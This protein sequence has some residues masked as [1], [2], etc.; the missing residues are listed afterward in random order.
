MVNT[1]FYKVDGV[2]YGMEYWRVSPH[3]WECRVR[4][5]E[6]E[7]TYIFRTT[8]YDYIDEEQIRYRCWLGFSQ[9]LFR[10]AKRMSAVSNNVF[11]HFTT[12]DLLL[13]QDKGE[14]K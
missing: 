4:D 10:R 7:T 14:E 5:P 6:S 1:D 2:V 8:I 11:V 3:D 12:Q 9:E 13:L